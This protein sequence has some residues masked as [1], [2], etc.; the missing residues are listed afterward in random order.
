MH[1]GPSFWGGGGG[2]KND[3]QRC[4]TAGRCVGGT[5]ASVGRREWFRERGHGALHDPTAPVYRIGAR[6]HGETRA[7]EWKS[8]ACTY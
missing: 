6:L 5:H 8:E 1:V 4:T 7:E 3:L 2:V